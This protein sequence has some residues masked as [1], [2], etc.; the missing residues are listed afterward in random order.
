MLNRESGLIIATQCLIPTLAF[1]NIFIL[2]SIQFCFLVS[3]I[4]LAEYVQQMKNFK[5]QGDQLYTAISHH[6]SLNHRQINA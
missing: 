1:S 5:L 2:I 4:R 3:V 6:S